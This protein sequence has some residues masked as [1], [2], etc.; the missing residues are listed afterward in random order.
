MHSILS[1]FV[2]V[3][4][5]TFHIDCQIQPARSDID[6]GPLLG[7]GSLRFE[8]SVD[9]DGPSRSKFNLFRTNGN[10]VDE[11]VKEMKIQASLPEED[12]DPE[13][14]EPGTSVKPRFNVFRVLQPEDDPGLVVVSDNP[15]LASTMT[16]ADPLPAQAVNRVQDACSYPPPK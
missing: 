15:P 11:E 5:F 4:L 3:V 1:L 8:T 12:D 2:T 7:P 6:D 14:L 16:R 10:D 9:N 13:E